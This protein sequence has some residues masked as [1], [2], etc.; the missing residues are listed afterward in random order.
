MQDFFTQQS[1]TLSKL[2][3]FMTSIFIDSTVK[4]LANEKPRQLQA[5]L[6]IGQ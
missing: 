2:I 5:Q 3:D 4:S 6:I 1:S